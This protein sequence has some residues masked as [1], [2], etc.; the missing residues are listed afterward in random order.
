VVMTAH[1]AW[2]MTEAAYARGFDAPGRQSYRQLRMGWLDWA[3]L[4]AAGLLGAGLI[5]WR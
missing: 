2:S 1:R 4:G 3:L 5:L